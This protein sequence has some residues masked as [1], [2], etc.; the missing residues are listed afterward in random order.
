MTLF[1]YINQLLNRLEAE[2]DI[3]II[4]VQLDFSD[5]VV[6]DFRNIVFMTPP[7]DRAEVEDGM[8]AFIVRAQNLGLLPELLQELENWINDEVSEQPYDNS[9]KPGQISGKE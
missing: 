7:C 5:A 4:A 8:S 6:A 3:D 1:N 2:G 9:Q